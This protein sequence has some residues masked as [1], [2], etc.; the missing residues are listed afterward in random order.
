MLEVSDLK[1]YYTVK[2]QG[3]VKTVKALDGVSFK[4]EPGKTLGIVGESG[5]GKSTLAKT[6]LLLEAKTSGEISINDRIVESIP[7]KEYRSKIQMVFQDPYNSLNPRKKAWELISAPISVIGKY[8]KAELFER[9]VEVMQKVGLRSEL[10]HRYPHMFSGGQRQRLG[11]ARALVS[12]PEILILD[13]PVSALD[14]SIQA[15]VLNLLMDLQDQMGLAYIFI[16]HD[17]SVVNHVSDDIMVMYLGKAVEFGAR[18]EIMQSPLHPYTRALLSSR[19]EIHPDNQTATV[20]VIQGELPSPL[21][22]PSGCTFH[23][24]C[25]LAQES[26]RSQI[27]Q[28][29]IKQKR[30]VACDIIT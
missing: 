9:A 19:P 15:Q 2:V 7:E 12:N 17:L 28:L 25:P 29:Q 6:L 1:K 11:L 30:L 23:K 3:K 13:E 4:V 10:A 14:V 8:S 18:Q 16:S 24:R 26:C 22:P 20:D 27:P 21:N 5:C